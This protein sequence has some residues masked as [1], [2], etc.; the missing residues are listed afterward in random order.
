LKHLDIKEPDPSIVALT[1]D[2]KAVAMKAAKELI[3]GASYVY[4]MIEN[5]ALS[6]EMRDCMC[7]LLDHYTK[8]ICEPLGYASEAAARIEEKSAKIRELNGRIR[9]LG[10]QLGEAAPIDTVPN[11]LRNL[12]DNV[13][14]WWKKADM[15][16][17]FEFQYG[18]Y[19]TV[20]LKFGFSFDRTFSMSSTPVS[21]KK[22]KTDKRND[23]EKQGYIFVIDESEHRLTDCEKNRNL[24]QNL[25][26]ERFPSITIRYWENRHVHKSSAFALWGIHAVIQDIKDLAI[27]NEMA[28]DEK[29]PGTEEES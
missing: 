19:G 27:P 6:V 28:S 22:S 25:L 13:D 2:Q 18:P 8:E 29:I 3:H 26:T 16:H 7:N 4:E 23:L 17:I 11:L 15:G 5:D 24:L 14:D 20:D 12:R 9:E 10:R 1:P 21:D